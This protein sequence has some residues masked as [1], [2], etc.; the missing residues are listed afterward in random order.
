MDLILAA[1]VALVFTAVPIFRVEGRFGLDYAKDQL[2][3]ALTGIMVIVAIFHGK[4]PSVS[5]P[6]MLGFF[7]FA[8]LS[9][10]WCDHNHIGKR[11][12][13]RLMAI[14]TFVGLA[15]QLPKGY[16]ILACFLPAPVVA[17]Q[18]AIQQIWKRDLCDKRTERGFTKRTRFVGWCISA[19]HAAAYLTMQG[20]LG[21]WLTVNDS[22]WFGIPTT[23]VFLGIAL[24]QCRAAQLSCLVGLA[25][26]FP[27]VIPF[28]LAGAVFAYLKQ[29]KCVESI[30]HRWL[31]TRAA[32]EIWKRFP[33][34]GAGPRCFRHKHS[35]ATA[36][37]NLRDETILGRPGKPGRYQF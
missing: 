24:S 6:W 23:I 27:L 4:L 22:S 36:E 10:F 13:I 3:T 2:F 30:G 9:I 31:M 33:I 25:V 37:L 11:E 26:L 12:V 5:S 34:F 29:P 16:L 28:L 8:F 19:N 7:G 17:I 18:G 32:F 14:F 35:R 15:S 21:I 20:F 1:Y